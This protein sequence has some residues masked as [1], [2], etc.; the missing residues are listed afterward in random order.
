MKRLLQFILTALAKAYVWRY[1]PAIIAVTGNVGKT[2]TK[3]AIKAVLG[4]I[5]KIRSG[6]GNL[7]NELGVPLTILGNWSEQYYESGGTPWFWF[8]VLALGAGRLIFDGSCPEILLLEFG[9]DRPKDIKRL[10][11]KFKPHIGVVTT[12]GEVPV[13]VEYFSGPE[14]V[15]KEKAKLQ[16]PLLSSDFAVLNHDDAAVLDMKNKTKARVTTFGF[17]DGATVRISNFDF[18]T[19]EAGRPAGTTF[20]LNYGESFVP[21]KLEDALGKSQA[22]AAAAAAAVGLIFGMNLVTISDALQLYRAPKG[23][24]K[25]LK[26]IKNSLLIDDT[27]NASPASMHIALETL[28]ML[29]LNTG[30]RIAVLGDMLELGRYSLDAHREIGNLVG[31]FADKLVCVGAKARFMA[32]SAANQMSG[33][34]IFV[35][36]ASG[37]AKNKVKE[38]LTEGDLV[39]IKGSQGIRMEK[40][41]EEIMAEPE[42]KGELLVRQN[43]KWLEIM[44]PSSSPV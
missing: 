27:Y 33:E 2:S 9:A 5:K 44:P 11:A 38:I 31:S 4:K 37:Q 20:K 34:N 29:P 7:N 41:V 40:I 1:K 35:F 21:V 16:E 14:A 24:L 30:R 6:A 28:K 43:K 3:E 17:T 18:R 23:R 39:L 22:W 8:K 10:T 25:L 13:H 15:A 12:V 42:R 32:D 36:D 19:D 26:G